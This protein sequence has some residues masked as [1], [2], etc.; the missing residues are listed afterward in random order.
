M[1]RFL[2]ASDRKNLIRLASELPQGS[3]ERRAILAGLISSREGNRIASKSEPYPHLHREIQEDWR[4]GAITSDEFSDLAKRIRSAPTLREAE[5]IVQRHRK[6]RT[7]SRDEV[8]EAKEAVRSALLE[9][10][11]RNQGRVLKNSKDVLS[12]TY[13]RNPQVKNVTFTF[14]GTKAPFWAE[15]LQGE[16]GWSWDQAYHPHPPSPGDPNHFRFDVLANRILRSGD[17]DLEVQ[18]ALASADLD[19]QLGRVHSTEKEVTGVKERPD[20]K[21]PS[22]GWTTNPNVYREP[23]YYQVEGTFLTSGDRSLVLEWLS[24]NRKGLLPGKH[25][26]QWSTREVDL[27]YDLREGAWIITSYYSYL[28]G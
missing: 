2:T 25:S 3:P 10:V 17:P 28:G 24:K 22:R 1:S 15:N 27:D 23:T 8:S 19:K 21:P 18:R 16:K 12:F 13:P 7:S 9:F 4:R 20:M 14:R 26:D 11:R 6:M 5:K